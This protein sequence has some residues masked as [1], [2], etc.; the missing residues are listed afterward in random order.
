VEPNLVATDF[1]LFVKEA[2]P[3]LRYALVAGYGPDRGL[4]GTA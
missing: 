2:E 3:R 4:D 1:T